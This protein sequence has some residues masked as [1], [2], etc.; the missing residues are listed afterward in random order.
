MLEKI[1]Q[2]LVSILAKIFR[3]VAVPKSLRAIESDLYRIVLVTQSSSI[4]I[5]GLM[6]S[7]ASKLSINSARRLDSNTI[8]EF[9]SSKQGSTSEL[10]WISL[11]DLDF[12]RRRQVQLNPDFDFVTMNVFQVQ[13]P[14]R[15]WPSFKP[16]ILWLWGLIPT[17]RILTISL[18]EK[19]SSFQPSGNRLIR[20]LKVEF[21]RSLKLVRGSP[22]E[23]REEQ[24]VTIL[25]GTEFERDIKV[26]SDRASLTIEQ[27]KKEALKAFYELSAN[28]R[29]IMYDALGFVAKLLMHRLFSEIHTKGIETLVPAIKDNTVVLVPMHRSHLDYILVGYKLFSEKVNPP[30]VAAGINLSFWPCGFIFRSVGAYFVKR[31]GRD[32]FHAI[33]L[34]RYISYLV[35]K[36]HLQEFFIEGGRSRS[37]KML[38]PKLG[39]LSTMVEAA[40][41]TKRRDLLFVPVSITYENIIEDEAYGKENSGGSK[42]K[43]TFLSTLKAFDIFK[44]RY[45]EVIIE[46]AKP[47][48]LKS[49]VDQNQGDSDRALVQNLGFTICRGIRNQINP[50]LTTLAYSAVLMSDRYGLKENELRTKITNIHKTFELLKESGFEI[51][52]YTSQLSSF[53]SGNT[54]VLRELTSA[55]VLQLEEHFDQK[56]YYIA[57]SSRF[58]ADYYRNSV[59]HYFFPISL[60]A[61]SEAVFGAVDFQKLPFLYKYFEHDLIL[62]TWELYRPRLESLCLDLSSKGKMTKSEAA[63]FVFNEREIMFPEMLA[64]YLQAYSWV[65]KRLLKIRTSVDDSGQILAGKF[66]S[67]LMSSAKAEIY[68]GEISRTEAASRSS[69]LSVIHSLSSRGL[70]T[71]SE[72]RES[73]RAIKISDNSVPLLDVELAELQKIN[74]SLT[75][76]SH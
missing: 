39:L 16:S 74:D 25:S 67:Q 42:V 70:I 52:T 18:G 6:Q 63:V 22:I 45:G 72:G 20:L 50:G 71:Y 1:K 75:I 61:L 54:D 56:Y 2:L 40:R 10:S 60:L 47:I 43:E 51:G 14:I 27:G 57:G 34:K 38:E 62:T 31:N 48:S 23:V 15:K 73:E 64:S 19:T 55:K 8:L 69:I 46:F 66:A 24:A 53:L 65:I 58:T 28:P 26:V 9:S 59:I 13:G 3:P 21:I 7:I 29:R 30:F 12:L 44:K 49:F 4:V 76:K 37:G 11:H 32:R 33:V 36:G 5:E 68:V 17:R 41:N 35:N